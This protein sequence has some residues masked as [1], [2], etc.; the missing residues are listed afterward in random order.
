MKRNLVENSRTPVTIAQRLIPHLREADLRALSKSKNVSG[1]V[2]EAAR[3]HLD[4][5]K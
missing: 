2:Q 4:R 3:R 1:A 5:K